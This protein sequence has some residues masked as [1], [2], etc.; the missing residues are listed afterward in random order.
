[1]LDTRPFQLSTGPYTKH[2]RKRLI[3][4]TFKHFDDTELVK[5]GWCGIKMMA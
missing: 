5:E 4:R 2:R 3:L 1:M